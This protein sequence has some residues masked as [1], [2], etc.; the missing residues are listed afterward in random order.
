MAIAT[1][2]LSSVIQASELLNQLTTLL[3]KER[4]ALETSDAQQSQAILP[5]KTALLKLLE[6]NAQER[7]QLLVSSGFEANSEGV[8][9][10]IEQ[11]PDSSHREITVRWEELQTQMH[12]CKDANTVNGKIIHR[13]R[14]QIDTLLGLL[15]G[16]RNSGKIYNNSGTAQSVNHNPMLAKA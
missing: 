14:Q 11:L 6:Q 10:F 12:N 1:N 15:Q 7:G 3:E 8:L 5:D 4:H 13:S 9:T 2:F 16:N